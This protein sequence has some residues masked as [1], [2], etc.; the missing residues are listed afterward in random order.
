V[1]AQNRERVQ[2]VLEAVLGVPRE[3]ITAAARLD[4]LA[5]LDSLSLA[6]LASALDREFGVL[7]P[8]EDLTTSL[9]VAD[10]ESIV[11]EARRT[12]ADTAK[13]T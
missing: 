3:S 12:A 11:E 5:P 8:G 13:D 7:I 2:A 6:E 9:R 1:S 4:E 10:L